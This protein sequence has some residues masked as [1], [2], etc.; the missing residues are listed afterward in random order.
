MEHAAAQDTESP[1]LIVSRSWLR[2]A[3][4]LARKGHR[5]SWADLSVASRGHTGN[6]LRM[7]RCSM[8]PLS[9]EY[10]IREAVRLLRASRRN[11][12]SHQIEQARELLEIILR[13]LPER[14]AKS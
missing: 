9:A 14:P 12:K 5:K 1:I 10:A 8:L 13:D 3:L 7:S 11:F 4:R 2:A 6:T